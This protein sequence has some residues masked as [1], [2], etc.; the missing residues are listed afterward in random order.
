MPDINLLQNQLKDT[1]A[2]ALARTKAAI[3]ILAIVL[4]LLAATAGIFYYLTADINKKTAVTVLE[5]NKLDQKISEQ[6]QGLTDAKSYQAQLSNIALLLKSHVALT[7]L[8]YELGKYTYLKAQYVN[9]DVAEDTGRIHLEGLVDS[10]QGL[11]KLLLGLSTSQNFRNV[12]LLS[13]A[14][15]GGVTFGYSFAIDL[16]ANQAIFLAPTK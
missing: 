5:N 15:S 10:Y 4:I 14:P 1:T 7:P 12:K 16:T 8:L 9:V 2:V 13:V 6:T 11:G 3:W